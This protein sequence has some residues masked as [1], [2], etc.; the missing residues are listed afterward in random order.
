LKNK[1]PAAAA[2]GAQAGKRRSG[3]GVSALI[4][5]VVAASKQR[6]GLCM[7]ELRKVLAAGGYDVERNDRRVT[8]A[9]R[10]LVR[11]ETLVQTGGRGATGS[12]ALNPA[13]ERRA[14]P[15]AAAT[16]RARKAAKRGAEGDRQAAA[17]TKPAGR[18]RRT[19][20]PV[21][22]AGKMPTGQKT[23]QVA[24]RRG[25]DRGK[26]PAVEGRKATRKPAPKKRR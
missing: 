15:A 18:D 5:R 13:R 11:R 2:A 7:A 3:G 4:L 8:A 9:V 1:R 25:A 20:K 16:E 14:K 24:D 22:A 23:T 12:F 17:K 19:N 6:G 21:G 10:G 26:S